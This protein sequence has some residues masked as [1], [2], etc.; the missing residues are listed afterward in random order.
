MCLISSLAHFPWW[1]LQA[2]SNCHCQL[3]VPLH[4]SHFFFQKGL[5]PTS[6]R[7]QMS[8]GLWAPNFPFYLL[9]LSSTIFTASPPGAPGGGRPPTVFS[10]T[11]SPHLHLGVALYL[12]SPGSCL[13]VPSPLLTEDL[14]SNSHVKDKLFRM[15]LPLRLPLWLSIIKILN[16]VVWI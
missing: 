5:P 4:P 3:P 12:A 9:D 8:S 14:P 10:M 1:L 2:F 6:W 11:S 16:T 13:P 15:F 7:K